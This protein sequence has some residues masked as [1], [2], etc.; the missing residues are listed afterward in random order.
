MQTNEGEKTLPR[1]HFSEVFESVD[2][3]NRA[4][5][6]NQFEQVTSCFSKFNCSLSEP[7]RTFS[8]CLC[9]KLIWTYILC[10][11]LSFTMQYAFLFCN[12]FPYFFQMIS[13]VYPIKFIK[14]LLLLNLTLISLMPISNDLDGFRI[15]C[16]FEDGIP[17]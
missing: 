14:L 16:N 17:A 6:A 8:P 1:N 7:L 15:L 4:F 13:S 5:R 10:I 2:N 12:L 3:G 11:Q 9:A